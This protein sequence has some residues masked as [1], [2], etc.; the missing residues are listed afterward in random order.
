[1]ATITAG[2]AATST[3][4]ALVFQRGG[5]AAADIATI[6][7]LI[8]NE[9]GQAD[10]YRTGGQV[11]GNVIPGGSFSQNGRLFIPN[12]GFLQMLPGDVVAIDA[13]GWP[14]LLSAGAAGALNGSSGSWR[15]HT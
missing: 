5:L 15:I 8:Q 3:L 7:Q 10:E 14:I 9:A 2:T 11:G 6:A 13:T 4:T 12:R 1:M